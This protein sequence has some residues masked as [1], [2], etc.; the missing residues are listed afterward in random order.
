MRAVLCPLRGALLRATLCASLMKTCLEPLSELG[1]AFVLC[2][3]MFSLILRLSSVWEG[4][5]CVCYDDIEVLDC[6]DDDNIIDL[7]GP[8]FG[9]TSLKIYGGIL[10][11]ASLDNTIRIWDYN[12]KL[13]T[14]LTGHESSVNYSRW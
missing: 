9:I 8:S 7:E 13:I 10:Y 2:M 12:S 5:P 11:S 3:G 1:F 6:S 4:V 14:T